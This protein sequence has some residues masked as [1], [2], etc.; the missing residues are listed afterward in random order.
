MTTKDKK[1]INPQRQEKKKTEKEP[2]E[3][4]FGSQKA[5]EHTVTNSADLRRIQFKSAAGAE[6]QTNLMQ[7]FR[8]T[9]ELWPH[10]SVG[11]GRAENGGTDR[12]PVWRQLDLLIF[13]PT[14]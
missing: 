9:Q 12:K 14:G 1:G 3:D 2:P 5:V 13:N 10:E 4:N 6:K 8:N 11:D 7:N